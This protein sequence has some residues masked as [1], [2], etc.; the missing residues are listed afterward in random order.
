MAPMIVSHRFGFLQFLAKKPSLKLQELRI[1]KGFQP[2]QSCSTFFFVNLQDK[3]PSKLH[4]W[5]DS[6]RG[7]K[8]LEGLQGL[9]GGLKGG[10]KGFKAELKRRFQDLKGGL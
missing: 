9:K 8:G 7:F 10:F 2:C 5:L 4:P 3:F 6:G 1:I